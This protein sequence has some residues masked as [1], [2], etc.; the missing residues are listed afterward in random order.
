MAPRYKLDSEGRRVV[1]PKEKTKERIKRS[2][3]DADGFNLAYAPPPSTG[4]YL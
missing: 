1:E 3:D 4:I 2:P